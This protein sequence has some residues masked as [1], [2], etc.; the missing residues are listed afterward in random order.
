MRRVEESSTKPDISCSAQNANSPER[1]LA[2][3]FVVAMMLK[4][5]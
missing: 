5:D 2:V 1:R 4:A 3:G